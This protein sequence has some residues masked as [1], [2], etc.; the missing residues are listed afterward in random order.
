MDIPDSVCAVVSLKTANASRRFRGHVFAPPAR[1]AGSVSG[2]S[3]NIGNAYYTALGA[4]IT[5]L[6]KGVIGGSG[7]AGSDLASYKLHV[8]SRAAALAGAPYVAECTD[9][10]L[11]SAATWLRS[12]Q[13]GGS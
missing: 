8:Y 1:T 10:I 13:H 5:E 11:R 4:W 6:K 9:V 3:L 7:W 2:V 12:R